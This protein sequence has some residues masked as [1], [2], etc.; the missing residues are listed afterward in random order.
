M[1]LRDLKAASIVLKT[2]ICKGRRCN[3]PFYF[4]NCISF[5]LIGDQYLFMNFFTKSNTSEI[6]TYLNIKALQFNIPDY[7]DFVRACLVDKLWCACSSVVLSEMIKM[8]YLSCL[9]VLLFVTT[10]QRYVWILPIACRT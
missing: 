5:P 9:N 1:L 8:I 4:I 6:D 2:K 3:F 10:L 7:V